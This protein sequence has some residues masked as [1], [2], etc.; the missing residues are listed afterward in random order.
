MTHVE[1]T[2]ATGTAHDGAVL[3]VLR[4]V[5]ALSDAMDRMHGGMKGDMDMNATDLAALRMLVLREQQSLDELDVLGT[6]Q[7]IQIEAGV[8]TLMLFCGSG[9]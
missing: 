3:N 8:E 4:A 2:S 9:T 5:Q 7:P 6:R 1:A